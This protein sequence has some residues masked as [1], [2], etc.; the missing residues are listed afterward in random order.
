MIYPNIN[1]PINDPDPICPNCLKPQAPEEGMWCEDCEYEF[2]KEN[3]PNL[4]ET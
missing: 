2:N 1:N 4:D 3:H